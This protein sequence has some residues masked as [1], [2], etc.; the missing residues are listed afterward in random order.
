VEESI[1]V[2]IHKKGDKTDC[3]NYRGIS[4]LPTTYIILS[5]I[6]L[7]TLIPYAKENIGIINVAI[8]VT[9]RLLIIY[10]A[11]AKY[12]KKNGNIMRKFISSL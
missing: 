1:I 12:L 11:F 8:D 3:S 9:G 6:L 10:S 2:P 5:N 7:S 4:L